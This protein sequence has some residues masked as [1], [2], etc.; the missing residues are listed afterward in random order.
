M[1]NN[2]F[3][4]LLERIKK[5]LTPLY[6]D[7]IFDIMDMYQMEIK[8]SKVLAWLLDA[9]ASHN[10]DDYFVKSFSNAFLND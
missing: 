3:K 10:L 8:H 2:G 5:E 6:Q 1:S 9:N 4:S 7:N